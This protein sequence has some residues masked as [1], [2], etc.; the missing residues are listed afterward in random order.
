MSEESPL[1]KSLRAAVDAAP[2]DVP[3][4]LH[5]AQLLLD[6]GHGQDAIS[7]VAAALQREPGN[8]EAQALIARAVAPPVTAPA[9]ATAPAQAPAPAQA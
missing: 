2:D 9:T 6:A 4:R 7:Q 5:L 1:I 8:A 3:L